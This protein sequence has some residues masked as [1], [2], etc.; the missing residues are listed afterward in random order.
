MATIRHELQREVFKPLEESL[1]SFVNV[2][3][4]L[5]KKKTSFLCITSTSQKPTTIHVYQVKKTDKSYKKK[6]SW[7]LGEL[8]SVDIK[9]PA[10]E[11]HEFDLQFDKNYRWYAINLLEKKKFL[12]TLWKLWCKHMPKQKS[13][14]RNLPEDWIASVN[15]SIDQGSPVSTS[16]LPVSQNATTVGSEGVVSEETDEDAGNY[17]SLT[18]KEQADLEKMVSQYEFAIS[19]AEAFMEVL[20][21][22]LS[23]LDGENVHSVLATEG[24]F[25][26]SEKGESKKWLLTG[27]GGPLDEAIQETDKIEKRLEDYEQALSGVRRAIQEVEQKN[28]LIELADRNARSL[29]AELENVINQLDLH[30]HHQNALMEADLS[31]PR[32]LEDALQASEALRAALNAQIHPALVRL[33]AV[34]GQRRRLEKL[35]GKFSQN[36]SRHLNNLFIHLGNDTAETF[37]PPID[38]IFTRPWPPGPSAHVPP[39]HHAQLAPYGPLLGWARAMDRR[40]YTALARVYS[41]SLGKLYER[42]LRRLFEEARVQACDTPLGTTG[43]ATGAAGSEKK[44][45]SAA[46]GHTTGGPLLGSDRETWT[47][48]GSSS[49]HGAAGG[50]VTDC[51]RFDEVL[52]R[53]LAALEPVCLS[54]QKFCVRF[55]HLDVATPDNDKNTQTTLDAPSSEAVEEVSSSPNPIPIPQKRAEKQ[56]NEEVRK[57]MGELFASL[58][59][60]LISFV[61][62]YEKV[63]SFYCMSVLVRLGQ[64][65]MSAQDAGSFLTVT[66]GTALVHAKRS[67]DRLMQAQLRSIQEARPPGGGASAMRRSSNRTTG[68]LPFVA[69][70]E[71]FAKTAESIFKGSVRRAD[72]DKWYAKL[73]CA[74]FEAIPRTAAEQHRTPA[75]VV[76]MENFHHLYALLSQLKIAVLDSLRK[77]AKQKYSEALKAYVTQYFGRP[78]EKLNQ[79]FEGVQAKVSQGVKESEI[80]FQMAFSKQELRRV[81]REY[82]AREVKRGLESLYRKVEKHLCEEENL[83]Q[84]VW[85]A[86]QEEFIQQYKSIEELIQ[87]CYPGSMIT[88]DF[89]IS[90]I[91]EFFSEIAR[92][93]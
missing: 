30:H 31:Q 39:K 12:T 52:E 61:A 84:V 27:S 17:R 57:M 75:E 41:S 70:F 25:C 81:I 50:G 59:S 91:L 86:M 4:V 3:K 82:P 10:E 7:I 40:A 49:A 55:F 11:S 33:G 23:I 72:L 63:D 62:H 92:S 88:L 46:P 85:R 76:K 9:T 18:E 38:E 32:G 24:M 16:G 68:I 71:D 78:L 21:R 47:A 89:T 79:F 35:K 60:E 77:D 43:P 44:T 51:R 54:E 14:F 56:M 42:D 13:P 48:D 36:L 28:A 93:H 26:R 53:A 80:S 20:A 67:F 65:V 69:N 73:V 8:I 22:D 45:S 2:S 90:D 1:E 83:L 5:K 37:S 6:N 19:N 87:R 58:E 66:F 29:L 64:H 34:Q 15:P 74:M